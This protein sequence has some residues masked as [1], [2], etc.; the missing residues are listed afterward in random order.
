[1]MMRF[2]GFLALALLVAGAVGARAQE[3]DPGVV[4]LRDGANALRFQVEVADTVEGRAT[5]LMDR[6]QMGRFSGML[7]VYDAPQSVAFWMKNTLIP[8]DMLF[9]DQTGKLTRVHKNAL[10][11]DETPIPGGNDILYVLEINGGLAGQL[12]IEAG[13]ELRHP[14]IDPDLAAWPCPSE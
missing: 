5:G 14:A 11:L 8:L 2:E 7:F 3:C 13:A 6:K 9:F 1:M 12:G 4:D 10:P